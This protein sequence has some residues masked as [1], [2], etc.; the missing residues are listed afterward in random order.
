[1]ILYDL[2]MHTRF[3]D[4]ADTPEEMVLAAIRKG[5]RQIGFSGHGYTFFD[6][7]Y[8][9]SRAVTQ[10]YIQEIH[11]L[12]EC[13]RTSIDILCGVEKDCFS[14]EP[15]DAF[16]YVIGSVHYLFVGGEYIPVDESAEILED[17]VEKH[18]GGDWMKL[19]ECYYETVATVVERTGADIIGHFDLITKFNEGDVLFDTA[20]SRYVRAWQRAARRLL[21]SGARFEI[22][23][24]AMSRGYRTAPYPAAPIRAYLE[25]KGAKWVLS[26]DAHATDGIGY[27]FEDF[28]EYIPVQERAL[29][30][31]K[32]KP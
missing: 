26:S 1:M 12:K 24:G 10:A 18:F 7:S 30:P 23:T 16:D 9:M 2:H 15:T 8:C 25:Q 5:F 32:E 13:Y 14:T 21:A 31:L 17:M 27:H 19:C 29:A 3:C 28:E 22:N 6:E 4:G 11:R 20:D